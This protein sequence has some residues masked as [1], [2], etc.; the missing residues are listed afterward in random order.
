MQAL[1][2][3]LFRAAAWSRRSPYPNEPL[4]EGGLGSP[5]ASLDA[6]LYKE[7]AWLDLFG[8]NSRGD[9]LARRIFARS[10]PGLRRATLIQISLNERLLPPSAIKI[11][12][13]NRLIED[14]ALLKAH[15]IKIEEGW[16]SVHCPRP[17]TRQL[18]LFDTHDLTFEAFPKEGPR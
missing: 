5:A 7:S 16:A 9:Q 17:K 8:H 6:A 18:C 4:L 11:Y 3:L 14:E 13:G 2:T 12:I 1:S 10:N 15:S